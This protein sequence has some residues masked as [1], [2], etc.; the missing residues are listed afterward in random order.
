MWFLAHS[1]HFEYVH[2]DYYL[3]LQNSGIFCKFR[4]LTGSLNWE[5]TLHISQ[6][7]TQ[8]K[9]DIYVSSQLPIPNYAPVYRMT[10]FTR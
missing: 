7:Y 8:S 2:V 6:I 5:M 3:Y 4:I 10:M 1:E 9:V